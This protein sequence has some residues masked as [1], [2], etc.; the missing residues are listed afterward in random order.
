MWAI[1]NRYQEDPSIDRE[2]IEGN[3]EPPNCRWITLGENV[4]LS[5]QQ[6]PRK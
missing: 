1:S 5:N 2:D 6:H 4:A 3:Y